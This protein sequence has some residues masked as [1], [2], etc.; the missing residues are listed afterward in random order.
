VADWFTDWD[1]HLVER[2]AYVGLLEQ[3]QD[4]VFNGSATDEGVSI[5]ERMDT[6]A[7]INRMEACDTI[8]D[9][10]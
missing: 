5:T 8:H 9:L 1:Q 10:P 3:G 6:F 7:H 2:H 4:I